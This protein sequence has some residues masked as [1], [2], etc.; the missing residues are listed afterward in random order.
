MIYCFKACTAPCKVCGLACDGCG[1]ACEG[2]TQCVG[3]FFG[4]ITRNP[5][6]GY[7]L[8]TWG[9]MIIVVLGSAYSLTN[10]KSTGDTENNS[11]SVTTTTLVPGSEASVDCDMARI[12]CM[13]MVGMAAIHALFAFYIQRRLV[14]AI[15]KDGVQNMSSREIAEKAK[16]LA[17]YDVAFCLYCPFFI[18]GFFYAMTGL[19]DMKDCDNTGPAWSAG[20]LLAFYQFCAGTYG[21]FWACCQCCCGQ[22]E[23]VT[24]RGGGSPAVVGAPVG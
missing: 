11:S 15:G 13:A 22:V 16:Q 4:P 21:F 23:S 17:M 6:G 5:L 18:G 2:C 14:N 24:G 1:K 10:M 20:T 12:Y 8:A 3:D 7:V 19:G 9:S